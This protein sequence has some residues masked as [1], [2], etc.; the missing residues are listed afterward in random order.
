VERNN[1]GHA[2]L[3]RLVETL[4]YTNVYKEGNLLGWNT[5]AASR[6]PMIENLAEMLAERP[7]LFQSAKLWN[8]CRTFVRAA[9][10]RPEAAPG[11][12]DDCVLAMGIA[13][14]VRGEVRS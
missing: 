11:A 8:E 7:E 2:V 14:A 12:H 10:G 3:M 6:P 13:V 9:D 5:S 1:H 4:K